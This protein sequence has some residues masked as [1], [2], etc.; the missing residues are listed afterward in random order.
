MFSKKL[1]ELRQ[2]PKHVKHRFIIVFL[3]ISFVIILI[4]WYLTFD[5]H[6][7]DLQDIGDYAQNTKSYITNGPKI[8]NEKIPEN[9]IS[10]ISSTSTQTN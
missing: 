4:I 5:F 8:F 1:K 10:N 6:R 9:I 3:S 2:K 7:F